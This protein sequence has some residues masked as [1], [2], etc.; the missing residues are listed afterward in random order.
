M[1]EPVYRK[2][3]WEL[4]TL[5]VDP[6]FQGLGVAKELVRWVLKKTMAEDLPV[7]VIGSQGTEPFYKSCGFEFLVGY[8]TEGDGNPLSGLL[9]GAIMWTRVKEDEG[10]TDD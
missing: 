6:T 4:S 1:T 9:G 7:V 3:H 5:G 8:T 2:I 10:Q